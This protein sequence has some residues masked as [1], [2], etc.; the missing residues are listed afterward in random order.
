MAAHFPLKVNNFL[1]PLIHEFP[2]CCHHLLPLLRI[3]VEET[4]VHLTANSE[5]LVSPKQR[6]LWGHVVPAYPPLLVLQRNIACENEA[7]LHTFL[8]I[9]MASSMVQDQALHQSGVCV[10]L[11]PH[12]HDL[13][14]EQVDGLIGLLDAEDL[15]IR[16]PLIR[17]CR[18]HVSRGAPALTE[19]TT[20][21]VS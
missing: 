3:V 8:H 1:N 19:S 20:M 2:L 21:S 7:I 13:H 9:W 4:R 15:L 12:V 11:V 18:V 14:H 17:D 10:E 5:H 6:T 16:P